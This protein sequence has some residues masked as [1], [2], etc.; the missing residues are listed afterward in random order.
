MKNLKKIRQFFSGICH[1]ATKSQS[2][3]KIGTQYTDGFSTTLNLPS[4]K[5]KQKI[6]PICGT[7]YFFHLGWQWPVIPIIDKQ[8]S[9]LS[10]K[11]THL[12]LNNGL[13]FWFLAFSFPENPPGLHR[14][15]GQLTT[16]TRYGVR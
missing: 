9:A 13:S 10:I 6:Q 11:P 5:L 7:K 14:W 1:I 2:E 15:N 8:K 12:E 4:S 3:S 16:Q